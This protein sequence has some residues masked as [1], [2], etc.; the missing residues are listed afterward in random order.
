MHFSFSLSFI[1]KNQCDTTIRKDEIV[2]IKFNEIIRREERS[3]LHLQN[4]LE[5][6]TAKAFPRRQAPQRKKIQQKQRKYHLIHISLLYP[7]RRLPYIVWG[8]SGCKQTTVMKKIKM[9]R[10]VTMIAIIGSQVKTSCRCLNWAMKF[11]VNDSAVE[12]Y[13]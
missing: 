3:D 5:Q 13:S 10:L 9:I 7:C 1:Q 11:S 2:E 12:E 4:L 6:S 8:L